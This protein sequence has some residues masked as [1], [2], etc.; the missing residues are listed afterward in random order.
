MEKGH[1]GISIAR[2]SPNWTVCEGAKN[3]E[4]GTFG[5]FEFVH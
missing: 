3:S 2:N 1:V 4:L 5:I